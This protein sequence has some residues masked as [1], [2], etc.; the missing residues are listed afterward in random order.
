MATKEEALQGIRAH[1]RTAVVAYLRC[2]GKVAK[3]NMTGNGPSAEL[4]EDKAKALRE[5]N[6]AR[7]AFLAT[8]TGP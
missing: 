2:L 3:A 1:Y 7:R 8:M 6:D 5:L 4:V